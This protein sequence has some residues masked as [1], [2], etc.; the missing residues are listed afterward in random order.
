M[1]S[2]TNVTATEAELSNQL[3]KGVLLQH[4][5]RSIH[6]QESRGNM[7]PLVTQIQMTN[8]LG[9]SIETSD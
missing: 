4:L 5:I 3:L 8:I 1:S 6:V 7:D 2:R 9:M